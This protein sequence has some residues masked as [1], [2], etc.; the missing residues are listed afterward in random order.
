MF[1]HDLGGK[2]HCSLN[3]SLAGPMTLIKSISHQG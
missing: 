3:P 1:V 2:S